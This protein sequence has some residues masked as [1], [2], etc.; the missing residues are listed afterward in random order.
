MIGSNPNKILTLLQPFGGL[1]QRAVAFPTEPDEPCI[2][3]VTVDSGDISQIWPHIRANR[4]PNAPQTVS[5]AGTGLN[6]E[7]A[8]IP[9]LVEG[10][11]RYCACVYNSEQ[12]ILAS[13]TELGD[14][15]LDLDTIPRCSTAE[16]SHPRCPLVAPNKNEPI[17][18]VQALSLLDG[19][20][21]YVPAAMVYLCAGFASCAERICVPISTGC[22]AHTS[23]Q[24]ALL[25]AT[26]EVIERDAISLLWL[27]ALPLPEIYLDVL[28]PPL[29]E[30]WERYQKRLSA[31]SLS[32]FNATTDLGVPT[33]YGVRV[34]P[35]PHR[36]T[37]VVCSSSTNPV[38]AVAK[39]IRDVAAIDAG[40]RASRPIPDSFDNFTEIFHGAVYMASHER[41]GTFKF[42]LA[43]G[44]RQALSSMPNLASGNPAS[45]LQAILE[46]FR[47]K[48]LAV[49]AVD[50][51]TDEAVRCGLRVVRVLIPGLQPLGFYYRA[52]YLGHPRLYQA[53]VEMGYV[54]HA[55]SQLNHWPQPFA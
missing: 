10:L 15:A 13:A 9:A 20:T 17:R 53:P 43:G 27:Q 2:S 42:L 22:A 12:F 3:T 31:T 14:R 26:L 16:L 44:R 38:E 54:A 11:E 5:G 8:L 52:R 36:T 37:A 55:E 7:Q 21:V 18:W 45:D 29:S 35:D 1:F 30:F 41:S 48:G 25:A 51:S 40:R 39:V 19:C 47:R 46:V 4:P 50:L 28:N 32:F 49:Y 34:S 6:E 24:K 23:Y 33:V